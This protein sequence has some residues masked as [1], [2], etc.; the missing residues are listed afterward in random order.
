MVSCKA[1]EREF[2][3]ERQLHAHIKAHDLRMVAYYQKFYA[4]YDLQAG[5]K[6]SFPTFFDNRNIVFLL[7]NL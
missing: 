5:C 6:M 7:A 4:R 3:S 2:D 1:C